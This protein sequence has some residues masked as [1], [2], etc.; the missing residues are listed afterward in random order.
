M[1][2]TLKEAVN[3]CQ[4]N[5]M[6]LATKFL[7]RSRRLYSISAVHFIAHNKSDRIAHW[8]H[9]TPKHGL[10]KPAKTLAYSSTCRLL[11]T[12]LALL[13]TLVLSGPGWGCVISSIS[14]C[15]NHCVAAGEKLLCRSMTMLLFL[16]KE[17][18]T[19]EILKVPEP[20]L[21]YPKVIFHA[22]AKV[23]SQ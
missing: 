15:Q 4:R 12:S 20:T 7:S 11:K 8:K 19:P 10:L 17:S 1:A 14:L 18:L 5:Q 13:V 9:R 2:I 22:Q 21:S 6:F 3:H 16:K 23:G